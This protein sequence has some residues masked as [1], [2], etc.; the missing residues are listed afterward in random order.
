MKTR[1]ARVA[2]E[3]NRPIFS[4]ALSGSWLILFNCAFDWMNVRGLVYRS[5]VNIFNF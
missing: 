4:T 2:D 1:P 5:D 3:L